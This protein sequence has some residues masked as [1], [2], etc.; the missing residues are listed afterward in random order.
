M[1]GYDYGRKAA[2]YEWNEAVQK[3]LDWIE[4]NIGENLTLLKISEQVGYSPYYCSVKFHKTC[5]MTIKRYIS[6]RR[7]ALAA[8]E[9]RDTK[10]RIIDIALKYGFSSQEALTR[11]FAAAFGCTP[12]AYRR[13]PTPVPLPIR[14][15]VFFPEHYYELY[16]GGIKMNE[17]IEAGVRTEFIPAH[18]YIGIW[19]DTAEDYFSFWAR[20][21]CD[22]ICG[23]IDSMSNVCDLIVTCH[24]AGWTLNG[25]KRCYF[26]GLGV[27]NDYKGA[28]PDGFEIRDIP[29]AYYLVFYHPPFDYLKDNGEVMGR[30][31]SLAWNYDIKDF[32]GGKY[33]WDESA[34]CYQ[35]HYP[36]GIGYEVLR[37]IKL[38]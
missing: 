37:P 1:V 28:V 24:T 13:N 38:K 10:E 19:D 18:R 36:E 21:N 15:V 29:A 25:C 23:T 22:E 2:L 20:H 31:E 16:K 35:R 7:L 8:L 11:A 33:V 32:G 26:Y 34:P 3:M 12:A 27:P 5:G 6:G 4:K 17:I 14:K 9:L 30:V